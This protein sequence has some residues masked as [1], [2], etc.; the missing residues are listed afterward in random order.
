MRI[1]TRFPALV[2]AALLLALAVPAVHAAPA[3]T[4]A[5]AKR[6]AA[7]P[8]APAASPLLAQFDANHDGKITRS[9]WKGN[10]VSFS[11]LDMNGDGVLTADELA[12]SV[13]ADP[14]PSPEAVR[15]RR[16]K[17]FRWMDA[18]HDGRIAKAEWREEAAKFARLDRNHDGVVTL[19]E[20]LQK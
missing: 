4:A 16:E 11:M 13:P 1:P 20:Y 10:D 12:P 7:E 3:Q 8:K 14:G 5:P 19:E 2:P 15:A 6:P 18:N 9:E 17:I